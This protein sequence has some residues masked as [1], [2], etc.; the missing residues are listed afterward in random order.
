MQ[1]GVT[2]GKLEMEGAERFQRLREPMGIASFGINLIRLQSGQRG[3]IH[4][5]ATQEEVYIVLAGVLSLA[6]GGKE[7]DLT[8]G[9][10]A[11]VAPEVR[12]QLVNRGP[13][14]CVVL[15]LGGAGQHVGRDGTAFV[16]WEAK[17]GAPPQE[18]PLPEDLPAAE[19]RT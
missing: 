10:L 19:R 9:E 11:R 17:E 7:R 13:A 4:H 3:R 16:S 6:V 14:P 18:T 1:E 5:H 15:A 12:R 2:Y 8:Q